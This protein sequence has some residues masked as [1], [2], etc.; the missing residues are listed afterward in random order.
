M[1]GCLA[2]KPDGRDVEH[3][4]T[5]HDGLPTFWPDEPLFK[6]AEGHTEAPHL[7]TLC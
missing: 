1:P 5:L 3:L 4:L 7:G 2:L 6:W